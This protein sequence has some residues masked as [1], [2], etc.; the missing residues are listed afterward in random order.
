MPLPVVKLPSEAITLS[1]GQTVE[2]RGLTF[3]EYE[4]LGQLDAT[5]TEV[6]VACVAYATGS[7]A[8][9]VREW[10]AATPHKDVEAVSMAVLRLSGMD[11]QG[12]AG[13]A[14]SSAGKRTPSRSSSQRS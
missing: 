13:R 6:M 11:G 8:D 4:K 14:P 3:A 5:G 12:E 2:L 7:T 1:D 9:A 10:F